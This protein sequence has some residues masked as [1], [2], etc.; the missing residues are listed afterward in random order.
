MDTR[1]SKL[2]L[3]YYVHEVD[4]SWKSPWWN[5]FTINEEAEN[6]AE[7][8]LATSGSVKDNILLLV[9]LRQWGG[10]GRKRKPLSSIP[11]LYWPIRQYTN[12]TAVTSWYVYYVTQ[13]Q[14]TLFSEYK[15]EGTCLFYISTFYI[16]IIIIIMHRAN[17]RWLVCP[18]IVPNPSCRPSVYLVVSFDPIS[19]NCPISFL[20]AFPLPLLPSVF[21]GVI[22]FSMLTSN[23]PL[24]I[25]ISFQPIIHIQSRFSAAVICI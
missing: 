4:F 7:A 10:G 12:S 15:E 13:I 8:H 18:S 6:A 9:L 17:W 3:Y 11:N 19:S 22:I 2:H 1:C 24:F 25:I 16:I 14:R 5:E 23:I 21:T 20:S